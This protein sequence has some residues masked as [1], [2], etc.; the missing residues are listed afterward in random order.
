VQIAKKGA[1]KM[2]KTNLTNIIRIGLDILLIA[3]L[4]FSLIY[5]SNYKEEVKEAMGTKEPDRLMQLYE[6]RT[7]TKCLCANPKY[8]SVIYISNP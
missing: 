3:L 5:V 1:E 8:G 6:E 2:N 4:V 7:E